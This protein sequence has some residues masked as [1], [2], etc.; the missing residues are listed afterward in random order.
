MMTSKIA[1]NI[2]QCLPELQTINT[3]YSI[4]EFLENLN[5]NL[6]KYQKY[7]S[8][9]DK[10]SNSGSKVIIK[11]QST[12]NSDV[13]ITLNSITNLFELSQGFSE[14]QLIY[15]MNSLVRIVTEYLEAKHKKKK[16]ELPTENELISQQNLCVIWRVNIQRFEKIYSETKNIVTAYLYHTSISYKE[17]GIVRVLELIKLLLIRYDDE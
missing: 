9:S 17:Y 10:S 13:T 14:N 11:S 1:I 15:L 12:F 3:W 2:G 16:S 5:Q 8:Q 4:L 6:K 7:I